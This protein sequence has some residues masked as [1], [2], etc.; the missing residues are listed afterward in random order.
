MARAK[1][2]PVRDVLIVGGGI[3]A[4]TAALYT[5]RAKMRPLI[6]AGTGMDQLSS[7]TLVENYPG[8]P[9]GIQGPELIQKCKEQAERFGAEYVGEDA[10]S[11]QGKKGA[12]EVAAG[13]TA[14][15]ARTVILATG[16]KARTLGIP[17]EKEFWGKGVSTC[18][19]CDAPFFKG[20]VVVVAGGG[21]SAMEESLTLTKFATKVIIV[22]RRDAFKA[23]KIMQDRVLGMKDKI[24]VVWS[25]QV[26]EVL[27][28]KFVQGVRVRDA[29]GKERAIPCGGFF[30][31]IG[32]DPN[33]RWLAG[34][35]VQLDP[36]GYI[37][38]QGV[39][40]SLP[41]V[42]AAGDAMDPHYRQAVISAGAGCMAALEAERHIERAKAEGSY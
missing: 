23:S 9:E 28:D 42:F 35:G 18:A 34:S 38:V 4:H 3:A 6:L 25:A 37:Q 31:A 27:G 19:P 10:E 21:D 2:A 11:L 8:F 1:P 22:H 29:S 39:T 16:A 15:R 7:T 32:H 30:L 41:G 13:G 40:T 20:K 33:T 14:Y 26:L 36:Q 5:A 12:Y 17:G 24:E